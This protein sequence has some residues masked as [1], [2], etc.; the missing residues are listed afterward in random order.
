MILQGRQHPGDLALRADVVVIGSGASGAV[1]ARELSQAGLEVVVLEE[2]GYHTPQEY[3]RF[4]PTETMRHMLRLGGSQVAVGVGDTPTISVMSGRAV[5]GSSTLTGGVCFRIPPQALARWKDELGLPGYSEEE[6]EACYQTVERAVG[7]REVPTSMRSRSTLLFAEGARRRGISIKPTRRNTSGCL[8]AARCN[9]GCPNEAKLSVDQTYLKEAVARGMRLYSDCLV[10]K[11][12]ERGGRAAGIEGRVLN[13][14][15]ATPQGR[16]TVRAPTV[17]VCAG[18]L[19]TPKI[20]RRSGVARRSGQLG[21]HLTL[22]PAFR[23]GAFF[24]RPVE[25]WK[26]AMQSAYSDALDA[27]GLTLIGIW[28][29]HNVAAT[30]LPGIGPELIQNL[31]SYPNL[32]LFGGMVH[33]EGGGRLFN[34]PGREPLI[35][36]RMAPR[37]KERL[38]LG[39]RIL[40]ECFFEAGARRVLLPIF[41]A[42]ALECPDDLERLDARRVPARVIECGSFHPLGSARMGV[43][44]RSA[45]VAPTGES[46]DLPGLYVADGSLFPTSIGVNSQLPIMAIATKIAWGLR[47]RLRA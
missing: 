14:P 43:D 20:L 22:H 24:D 7:V 21:R 13:G 18:T 42:E 34:I 16:L 15:G 46:F 10:E 9:F 6:L 35:V 38:L 39:L 44:P 33:D 25:G 29:P 36:Y 4:R 2:G 45:C 19:H 12:I 41:G 23:V 28:A 32:A 5:G 37:D 31:R 1:V 3:A 11:V 30:V 17:V 27:R 47:D 26:G 8:G 40:A